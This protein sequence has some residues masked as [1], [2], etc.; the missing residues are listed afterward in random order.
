MSGLNPQK[1]K[2]LKL[3]IDQVKA[4]PELLY[5]KELD[6]F[7]DFMLHFGASLPEAKPQNKPPKK[8]EPKAEAPKAPVPEEKEEDEEPDTELM[9]PDNDPP[10]ESGDPNKQIADEDFAKSS[11]L[12]NQGLEKHRE[13]KFQE[14]IDL[15]TQAIKLNP[16]S[17]INY[18][19]RAQ[20]LLDMKKPNAA[21][22]DCDTAIKIA[23]DSAKP[24][25]VRGRALRAIGQY[26]DAL[27]STQLGQKMD[28]DE[29]THKFENE[30]K[31]RVDKVVARKKKREEARKK[32]EEEERKN[33]PQ[34]E[35]AEPD[36]G[37]FPGM[38]GMPGM[39]GMGG[40][41]GMSG[42][43]GGP[44]MFSKIMSD[45]ELMTMLQDP[46][47]MSVM[48]EIMTDPSKLAQYQSD[49]KIA[50]LMQKLS[51]FQ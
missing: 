2:E 28:W 21:I 16:N 29:N 18:A 51:A 34:E 6:F 19:S 8:E 1:L 10:L 41:P 50:K 35:E 15:L 49:P 14:S 11:Q 22:R 24:H 45:P 46:A 38:G 7:K 31:Q 44:E 36:F 33:Q 20:V 17:G 48:Q 39:P 37:D 27:K 12:K 47:V 42:M 13:K 23:P 40:M 9:T 25:K 26:E 43:P 5:L 4:N 30:L 32:R 3:F